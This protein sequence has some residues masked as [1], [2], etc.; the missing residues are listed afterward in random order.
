MPTPKKAARRDLVK[1]LLPGT[2][3]PESYIDAYDKILE[4]AD[5]VGAGISL[6]GIKKILESSK[7]SP[8]TQ[9]QVLNLVVPGGHESTSGLGRSEFNVL[10]AL[11]GLGQEGEDATLDG[12]DERR[13]SEFV[14]SRSMA[15]SYT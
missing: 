3:V 1:S 10:L 5:R 6:T 7:L 9:A 15:S 11:I 12:V 2:D 4:S 13:R 8:S 14:H